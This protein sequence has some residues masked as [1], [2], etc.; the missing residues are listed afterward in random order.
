MKKHNSQKLNLEKLTITKI[1]TALLYKIKGGT[2]IPP[3]N[4]VVDDAAGDPICFYA[5]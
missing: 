3:Q 1:D 2:S 5:N 4:T